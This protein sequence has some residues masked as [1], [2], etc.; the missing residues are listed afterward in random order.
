LWLSRPLVQRPSGTQSWLV[1]GYR[2]LSATG[3]KFAAEPD[4]FGLARVDGWTQLHVGDFGLWFEN[5][6][7]KLWRHSG[8]LTL[9]IASLDFGRRIEGPS[10]EQVSDRFVGGGFNVNFNTM[11]PLGDTGLTLFGG[12]DSSLLAGSVQPTVAPLHG[13]AGSL[14][15]A[16]GRAEQ[17]VAL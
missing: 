10:G 16:H 6:P 15:P 1:L 4:P 2:Y 14:L 12:F 17:V 11:R 8:G 13:A 9:R 3:A 5:G 7:G